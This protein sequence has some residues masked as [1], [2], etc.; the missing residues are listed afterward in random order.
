L[1]LFNAFNAK[2]RYFIP[3]VI[4]TSAMDCGPA[5]LKAVLEGY[6]ISASYERLREVCQTDVS[7]TSIY[8]NFVSNICRLK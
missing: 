1:S 6:D 7:G 4:Q 8:I 5:T 3:E 2:R